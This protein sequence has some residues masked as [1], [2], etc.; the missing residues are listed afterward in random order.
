M[1]HKLIVY[2][3]FILGLVVSSSA[4]S[5]NIKQLADSVIPIQ[6]HADLLPLIEEAAKAEIVLIG[7]STHGTHEFYQ[8]RINLSKQLIQQKNFKLVTLEADWP[9]IYI[10]NLY[11]HSQISLDEFKLINPIN[12]FPIWMWKNKETFEFLHWLREYNNRLAI[13]EQ[14]VSLFGLDIYSYHASMAWVIDYFAMFHPLMANQVIN[15]FSCLMRFKL[16]GQYGRNLD[17]G[18]TSSC[19]IST[20]KVYAL[21]ESC[22]IQ[23]DNF[24][25]L[26]HQNAFF[27]AKQQAYIAQTNE[28]YYRSMYT[29]DNPSESWNIRDK[30]MYNTFLNIRKQFNNPKTLVW[31]HNSHLGDARATS[32][33][34]FDE[35]NIGQL[36]REKFKKKLFSIGMLTYKGKVIAADEWGEPFHSK[37]LQSADSRSNEA[38]FH[39]LKIFSFILF[40]KQLNKKLYTW[41]NQ[42]RFQRHVGVVYIE[43]NEFDSH[44]T[45]TML[46]EQ[47]DA[48][49]FIDTTSALQWLKN[50]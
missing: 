47:F 46:M 14:K 37:T 13:G 19:E 5:N 10:F 7:D 35:L 30:Y 20:K 28:L 49:Y 25:I 33:V 31:A 12:K 22:K 15:N 8:Q 39:Q 26:S 38:L 48:L 43:D 23:C 16:P 4:F 41:L 9:S 3:S 21:F 36:L 40:P 2:S 24:T 18:K 6:K 29:S 50:F 45:G 27:Q 11:V 17:K 42:K 1:S 32:M 44:Y 34:E